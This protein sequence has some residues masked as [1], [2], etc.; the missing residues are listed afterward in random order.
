MGAENYAETFERMLAEGVISTRGLKAD[1]KVFDELVF[2]VNTDYFDRNGGYEYA[3]SFFEEA[4][5]CA[6][7]EIGGE[8]YILSAV[9][10]ADGFDHQ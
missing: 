6:V 5:R 9:M 7:K 10:H 1:A 2:D 3:K 4:Y 8:E